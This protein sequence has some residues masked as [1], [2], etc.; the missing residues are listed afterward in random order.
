MKNGPPHRAQHYTA[1]PP[2]AV[3]GKAVSAPVAEAGGTLHYSWMKIAPCLLFICSTA[4]LP[5][6][7][8]TQIIGAVPTRPPD[9]PGAPKWIVV[10]DES[11]K[12]GATGVHAAA[13]MNPPVD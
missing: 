7:G 1:R 6:V 4:L 3:V 12:P 13:G 9:G 10:G 2:G 8:L 5:V 11:G